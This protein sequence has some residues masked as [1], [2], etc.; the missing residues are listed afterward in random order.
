MSAF[1]F[2]P[3]YVAMTMV[4]GRIMTENQVLLSGDLPA[5]IDEAN[6]AAVRLLT[7]RDDWLASQK[8]VTSLA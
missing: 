1:F 8:E 4:A 7:R 6:A 2:N 3:I 5:Y